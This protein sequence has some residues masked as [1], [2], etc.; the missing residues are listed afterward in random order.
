MDLGE[1]LSEYQI[2][3]GVCLNQDDQLYH[4]NRDDEVVLVKSAELFRHAETSA[5]ADFKRCFIKDTEGFY[6]T[7]V[8]H[9]LY[10]LEQINTILTE[11]G[12]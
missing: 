4:P 9:K 8:R 6:D 10:A 3:A 11:I 1:N 7:F 12:E 5:G 2:F